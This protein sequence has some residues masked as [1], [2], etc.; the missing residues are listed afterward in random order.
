[1]PTDEGNAKVLLVILTSTTYEEIRAKL[2]ALAHAAGFEEATSV[3]VE[4]CVYAYCDSIK[5]N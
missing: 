5:N 4:K 1:M 3:R 2:I